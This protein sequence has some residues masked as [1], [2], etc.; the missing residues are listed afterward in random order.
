MANS[1]ILIIN[2]NSSSSVTEVIELQV[3]SCSFSRVHPSFFTGPKQSPASIDDD[4]TAQLST[5]ACLPELTQAI[6][7]YDAFLVA[8]YSDH[9][10]VAELRKITSKPVIGILEASIRYAAS[11]YTSRFGVVT[12]GKQWESLLSSAIHD[13]LKDTPEDEN[14]F[15]GVASSGLGVLELHSKSI[16]DVKIGL[17]AAARRLVMEND[18]SII[19]LGCA[20]MAGMESMI[21]DSVKDEKREVIVVDGVIAGIKLLQNLLEA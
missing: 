7:S 6:E 17:G 2:P 19:C 14:R 10:L 20:G 11:T 16:D 1:R 4:Y 21:S 5:T 13:L 3:L 8:C 15:G 18:V 9:P 12:T